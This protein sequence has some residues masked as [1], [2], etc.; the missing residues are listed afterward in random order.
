MLE[1]TWRKWNPLI[2]FVRMKIN[3]ATME[4]NMEIS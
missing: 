4:N 2:L 1:W 3:T